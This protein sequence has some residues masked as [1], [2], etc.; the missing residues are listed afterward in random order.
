MQ[1]SRASNEAAMRWAHWVLPAG[2][3]VAQAD[4]AAGLWGAHSACDQG[5]AVGHR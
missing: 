3:K 2:C 1:G 4:T 5:Y